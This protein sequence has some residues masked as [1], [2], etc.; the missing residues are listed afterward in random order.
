MFPFQPDPH[1]LTFPGE[2]SVVL[3]CPRSLPDAPWES[4][5]V[6]TAGFGADRWS[7]GEG[8]GSVETGLVGSG[9]LVLGAV[10]G[11]VGT[12]GAMIGATIGVTF[13]VVVTGVVVTG[14]VVAGDVVTGVVDGVATGFE[15]VVVSESLFATFRGR[16]GRLL[17]LAWS[18]EKAAVALAVRAITLV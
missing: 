12:I 15:V 9:L 4:V 3:W 5:P 10:S 2:E 16:F 7:G 8:I 14:V 1:Q 18:I 6:V 13:G 11:V 17:A